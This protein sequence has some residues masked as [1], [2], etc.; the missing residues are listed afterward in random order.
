MSWIL[1][2][3]LGAL[4][5]AV[6]NILDKYVVGT[7]LKEIRNQKLE[8]RIMVLPDHP[9]PIKVMTH[10]ADAVPFAIYPL[11]VTSYPF[12]FAQGWHRAESRCGFRVKG[13]NEKEIRKSKLRVKHGHRLI[14][15]FLGGKA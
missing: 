13:F 8:I 7:I 10:T 9:T 12:D 2:S 14:K 3:I 6:V 15:L 1:F 11:R 4:T 5:W